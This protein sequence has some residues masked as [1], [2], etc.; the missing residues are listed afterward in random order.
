MKNLVALLLFLPAFLFAQ[1][2]STGEKPK[3]VVGIVVD[4]LRYDYLTRLEK[5]FLPAT[6]KSGGFN[7]LL[8]NG[9]SLATRTS[10]IP[11]RSRQWGI[12]PSFR[13]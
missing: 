2:K 8:K 13:A 4:Q 12:R 6:K 11:I 1:S 7:R 9:A 3:L 10:H 5:H